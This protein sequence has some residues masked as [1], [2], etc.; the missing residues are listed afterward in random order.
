MAPFYVSDIM[1]LRSDNFVTNF[2]EIIF[3]YLINKWHVH[4]K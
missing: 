1:E 4:I 3:Y 2:Y